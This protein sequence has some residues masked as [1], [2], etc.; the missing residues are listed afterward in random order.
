M[1]IFYVDSCPI[2]SAQYLVDKHVVKMIL[3]SAQ[4]L[5]TA[6]RVLDGI[7]YIGYSQSGRKAKRWKLNDFRDD[8][9]YQAT[10][11]HHPSN[12]W[13]RESSDNYKWLWEHLVALCEEYSFR[14]DKDHKVMREGL[15]NVLKTIPNNISRIGFNQ[16]TPAMDERY[17]ISD[18]SVINYR[19][20]YSFGKSHLFSWKRRDK[21]DWL[22]I[23][24]D[25]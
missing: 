11:I 22:N 17:I 12:V 23:A 3:E 7:E 10:H 4:L 14:Y 18:D 21:P 24:G 2:K 19:N 1:N 13:V 20:Y 9:L 8:I 15:V 6:H 16:P 5:S 25:K